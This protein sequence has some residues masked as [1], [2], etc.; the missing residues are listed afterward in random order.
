LEANTCPLSSECRKLALEIIQDHKRQ[1]RQKTSLEGDNKKIL[2]VFS[3]TLRAGTFF[4]S[5]SQNFL[6]KVLYVTHTEL[7]EKDRFL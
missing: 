5:R 6:H 4:L 1:R 7:Y 2:E 3:E